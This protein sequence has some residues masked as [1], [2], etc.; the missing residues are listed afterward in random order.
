MSGAAEN[1]GV[2]QTTPKA[3]VEDTAFVVHSRSELRISAGNTEALGSLDVKAR[4]T[5]VARRRL[6]GCKRSLG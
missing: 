1:I 2:I 6:A 3:D 5:E 4:G